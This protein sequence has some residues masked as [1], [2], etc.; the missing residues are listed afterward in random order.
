MLDELKKKNGRDKV[1][2]RN[3]TIFQWQWNHDGGKHYPGSKYLESA[4]EK[5]IPN[6]LVRI[7]FTHNRR[8]GVVDGKESSKV[9]RCHYVVAKYSEFDS[10][11]KC[12]IIR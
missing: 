1:I 6:A 10:L 12:V 9:I 5:G 2:K 4:L 3:I 7:N 8:L 11:I